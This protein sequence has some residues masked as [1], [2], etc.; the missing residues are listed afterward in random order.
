MK[1]NQAWFV[2][3]AG[4]GAFACGDKLPDVD[5]SGD[6]PKYADVAALTKCSTCHS[7]QVSSAA[8]KGAPASINFDTEAAANAKAEDAASEVNG[9][10]MPPAG[11]GISLSEAEKQALYKWALCR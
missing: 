6:V 3:A 5:C 9:G 1:A 4:I 2:F 11:S 7:S 10:D 8:R